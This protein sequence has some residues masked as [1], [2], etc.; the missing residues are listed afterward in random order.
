MKK[1]MVSLVLAA[2]LVLSMATAFA[3]AQE[4]PYDF[5]AQAQAYLEYIGQNLTNRNVTPEGEDVA[6]GNTHDE[7]MEWI[8]SELKAAGYTDEQIK[9]ETVTAEDYSGA[10]CPIANIELTVEGQQ[11]EKQIIIGAHY[12][13]DGAGDNGSGIALMLST[14]CGLANEQPLYTVKYVFFD[15]EEIGLVGAHL[16]AEA[17]TE[18]EVA[19]TEFMINIDSVAFG[20][21]CNVYGGAMD[22]ETKEVTQTS[23]YELAMDKAA[24]LG[25]KTYT[26]E[27]LDGYYAANGAGPEIEELALYTNP[28]T[29]S[30]PAPANADYVSPTTGDW[31]DH[32][33]FKYLG[34]PY[35]YMEATNWYAEGDGGPDAYTGYFETA[36]ASLGYDGMFM[37]TEYDTLENLNSFFPGRSLA[38]FQVFSPLLG[39]LVMN[40]ASAE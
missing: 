36:D 7:T 38:H 4:L 39:S 17:M 19:S 10:K 26:T 37:N 25:M 27:D 1:N 22:A 28:W 33:D 18:E 35:L 6:E 20:D 13:G 16:Y 21:Y 34:I 14:A 11:P 8:I 29:A 2:L 15:G 31:S 5:S 32:A 3:E 30:N 12:D 23:A 24:A 9:C 40:P